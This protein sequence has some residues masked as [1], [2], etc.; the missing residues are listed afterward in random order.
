M[1]ALGYETFALATVYTASET[2]AL[3]GVRRVDEDTPLATASVDEFA[4]YQWPIENLGIT[5]DGSPATAGA[6]I[7]AS[8]AWHRIRGS[9]VVVAVGGACF[10][11]PCRGWDL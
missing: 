6:D 4:P 11:S 2:A 7:K 9:G 5:A 8:E 10:V 1:E 3:P